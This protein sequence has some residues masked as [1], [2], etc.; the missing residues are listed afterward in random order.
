MLLLL[1]HNSNIQNNTVYNAIKILF[2]VVCRFFL[3]QWV[4]YAEIEVVLVIAR[5]VC[6]E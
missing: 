2:N 3:E 1:H 6:Y 4:E 5:A